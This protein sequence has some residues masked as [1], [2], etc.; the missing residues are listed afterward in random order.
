MIEDMIV[1]GSCSDDNLR[2]TVL[3]DDAGLEA[4]EDIA[5]KN[6]K[7]RGGGTMCKRA[8]DGPE[9]H[10]FVLRVGKEE[11]PLKGDLFIG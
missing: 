10:E 11:Q 7:E 2:H 1:G 9:D 5:K 6:D 3:T 8:N 4:V